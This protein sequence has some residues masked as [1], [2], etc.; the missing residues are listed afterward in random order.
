MV[1]A[2]RE[3]Y[4]AETDGSGGTGKVGIKDVALAKKNEY[5]KLDAEYK[6]LAASQQPTTV[7]ADEQLNAINDSIKKQ[8]AEFTSYFNNG[9]LTRIEALNNLV[10]DNSAL[11]FRYY[12]I[13]IIL[14]LIEL[15]PVISKTLLPSGTYDERVLL[16]EE[17]E[18]EM[19]AS[20]IKKEQEL[21]ELYNVLAK[22]TDAETIRAFF[23][24]TEN[25]RT[26]KIKAFTKNWHEE[27]H[28]AFDNIWERMKKE[29]LTKQEN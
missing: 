21:K 24:L 12:L 16:R 9:F 5:Q 14:L 18:R 2:A 26:E 7:A 29:V 19:A 1:N 22:E 25:E 17:M 27:K 10:K 6:L 3:N 4:L 8:E 23:R 20:N 15:M 28:Q 13:V 11:Q